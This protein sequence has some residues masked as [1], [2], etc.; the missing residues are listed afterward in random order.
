MA[1]KDDKDKRGLAARANEAA[2]QNPPAGNSW[3][4]GIGINSYQAFLPLYN[5]V[6]DVEDIEIQETQT[7][8]TKKK[9]VKSKSLETMLMK[10]DEEI[11]KEIPKNQII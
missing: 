4:F 5:A 11:I 3:F 2:G 8:K 6:K 10:S 9:R 1:P 7:L